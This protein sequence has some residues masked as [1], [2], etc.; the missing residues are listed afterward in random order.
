MR[1]IKKY[2]LK[3][4]LFRF[5]GKLIQILSRDKYTLRVKKSTFKDYDF[6]K[7]CDF[8]IDVGVAYGTDWIE[9]FGRNKFILYVE[10]NPIFYDLIENKL[11]SVNKKKRELIKSGAGSSTSYALLNNSEYISSFYDRKSTKITDSKVEVKIETIDNIFKKLEPQI[12]GFGLLKIDTEGYELEVLKGA[13]NT[14]KF[15]KHIIVELRVS[16]IVSYKPDDL[17]SFLNSRGFY[18]EKVID[19]GD[20]LGYLTYIDVLFTKN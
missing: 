18:W 13:I 9:E 6:I 10:A 11:V 19:Y 3:E 17:V 16:D 15:L 7:K 20:T 5:I 1:G 2:N 8:I 14:F 4:K 12:K